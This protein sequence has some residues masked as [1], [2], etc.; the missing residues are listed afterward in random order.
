MAGSILLDTNAIISLLAHDPSLRTLLAGSKVYAPAVALGE[1]Y[2]GAYKSGQ[3]E[4]N[5]RRL[6]DFV[7]DSVVVACDKQ[8]AS[9]YGQLKQA[10][11]L[12]GRPTPENDIWIGALARQHTLPIVTRDSHFKEFPDVSLATW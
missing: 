3:V 1:M 7:V 8:T 12:K 2:F 5:L 4:S 11:R 9:H 10:L 6:E